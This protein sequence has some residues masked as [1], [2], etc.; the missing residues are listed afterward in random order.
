MKKYTDDRSMSI[1]NN[2]K[3]IIIDPEV[4]NNIHKVKLIA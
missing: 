4:K 1:V 2:S 3:I